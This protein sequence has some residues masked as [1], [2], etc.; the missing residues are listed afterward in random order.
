[1]PRLLRPFLRKDGCFV[2]G[3][4]HVRLLPLLEPL[5]LAMVYH[6]LVKKLQRVG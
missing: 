5:L 4:S 1:M 2:P 3:V 6:L